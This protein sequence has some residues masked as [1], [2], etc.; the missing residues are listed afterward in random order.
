MK[1]DSSY[2]IKT[3]TALNAGINVEKNCNNSYKHAMQRYRHKKKCANTD[4]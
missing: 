4:T 1:E 3:Y 2:S